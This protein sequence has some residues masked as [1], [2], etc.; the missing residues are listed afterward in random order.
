MGGAGGRCHRLRTPRPRRRALPASAPGIATTVAALMCFVSSQFDV[1]AGRLLGGF[2]GGTCLGAP[3]GYWD[4]VEGGQ[5]WNIGQC[6]QGHG[7]SPKNLSSMTSAFADPNKLFWGYHIVEKPVQIMNTGRVLTALLG[8]ATGGVYLGTEF[9]R[10][11]VDTYAVWK[12]E[13]HTPSEH[14]FDGMQVP[15]ELQIFHRRRGVVD[16]V[17][18]PGD[19]AVVSFGFTGGGRDSTFLSAL[20]QGELPLQAGQET[21]VNTQAPAQ[22]N[23]AELFGPGRDG[24]AVASFWSYTGSLTSPPCSS[25]VHW[26]VRQDPL[27]A[28]PATLAE[29]REAIAAITPL[30]QKQ[31]GNARLLQPLC[32]AK[33]VAR[34]SEDVSQQLETAFKEVK[35]ERFEAAMR[36]AEAEKAAF[37][38]SLAA[39]PPL[40]QRCV[41]RLSTAARQLVATKAR[42][43]EA[44]DAVHQVRGELKAASDDGL[45]RLKAG[46][47]LN[48]QKALCEQT[49]KVI[50]ALTAEL[51]GGQAKCD[52]LKPSA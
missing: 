12:L 6:C 24:T 50:A 41:Q 8:S 5:N 46:N 29:F 20:H 39:P 10:V 2:S 33:K 11:L 14:T 26:F 38:K 37:E 49:T 47:R 3:D 16:D 44:C 40:Y 30:A 32:G 43:K 1:A 36:N 19:V 51:R 23:F 15:L 35:D 9:P 4:Y 17:P 27:L 7:Q 48:G 42:Q 25:G 22:L 52:R 34:Q 21:L 18:Y 45:A 28:L 31:V 13:I